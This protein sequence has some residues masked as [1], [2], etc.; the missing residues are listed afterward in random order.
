M[1][2]IDIPRQ[3]WRLEIPTD[4]PFLVENSIY[5]NDL[6]NKAQLGTI[7]ASFQVHRRDCAALGSKGDD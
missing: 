2:V 4:G 5:F 6:V 1:S 3:G 7:L